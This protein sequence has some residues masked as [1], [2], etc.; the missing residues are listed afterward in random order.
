[1]LEIDAEDEAIIDSDPAA[2]SKAI[3]DEAA[4]R[5]HWWL[6]HWQ[7]RPRGDIPPGRVGSM[8]DVTIRSG[9]TVRFTAKVVEINDAGMRIE[10]VGGAYRG[11][12]TWRFQPANG[13]TRLRFR[14]RVRPVGWLSWLLRLSPSSARKAR[15]H[16]EV[17][18]AAFAGLN[19]HFNALK[20]HTTQ[21]PT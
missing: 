4:G 18:Q 9:L 15:Y 13:K 21:G 3:I 10:Y 7:A 19:R 12:G 6:P 11:E 5:T 8:F 20:A 2:V 17:M 1:M 16:H 14:W